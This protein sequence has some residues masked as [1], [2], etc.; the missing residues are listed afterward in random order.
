[1]PLLRYAAIFVIAFFISWTVHNLLNSSHTDGQG[2]VFQ[3]IEVPYGSKT[4]LQL[5]DGSRVILNSGSTLSYPN[6]FEGGSRTVY[7]TGEAFFDVKKDKTKPFFV[8][9]S[10]IR[11]KVLGTTFN[12]KAYPEEGTVETTLVTGEVQIFTGKQTSMPDIT[13]KPS[14]KAVY[15]KD[16]KQILRLDEELPQKV[17]PVSKSVTDNSQ[18]KPSQTSA[19][20]NESIAWKDNQLVF[21]NEEFN[22]LTAK[23]ERWFNVEIILDYPALKNARFSGKFDKE[24]IEQAL[25]AMILATPF[26]YTISKNK[27]TIYK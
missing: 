24:T 26:R 4:R 5:P 2:L 9:A 8:N 15:S 14:Q 22:E 1:M 18:N 23:I 16:N 11:V 17:S 6:V 21:D 27:I 3:K 12:V 10:G 19:K 25:N 13:L 20:V 7:L